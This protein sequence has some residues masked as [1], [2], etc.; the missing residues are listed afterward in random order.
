M[1]ALVDDRAVARRARDGRVGARPAVEASTSP[2]V[3]G[4]IALTDL[5]VAERGP[6]SW[7]TPVTPSSRAPRRARATAGSV[8][9]QPSAPVITCVAAIRSLE[10]AARRVLQARGDD[11]DERTSATPIISAAAVAD[12]AAGLAHRVAPRQ[13]A[14]RRR[15]WPAAGRPSRDASAADRARRQAQPARAGSARRAAPRPARRAS[16]ATPGSG[17]RRSVTSMPTSSDDD[18]R[19]RGEHG[20]GLRQREP[21]RVEQRVEPLA[22][23]KPAASPTARRQQADRPAPRSAPSRAPGGARRRPSAAARAH[24]RAGRR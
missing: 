10:R 12:R 21:H 17:R 14:R 13:P 3:A 7:R 6:R 20:A 19:A 2:A 22:S 15:R 24:A 9:D 1:A 5:L 4:S 11:R 8:G 18:D 23:P 16:P